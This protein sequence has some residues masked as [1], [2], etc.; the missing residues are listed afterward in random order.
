VVTDFDM[1]VTDGLELARILLGNAPDLPL[2]MVTGLER[3]ITLEGVPNIKK[4][5]LK[6][7]NGQELS[8]AI[9][10]VLG[11]KAAADSKETA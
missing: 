8:E 9:M 10:E 2:I 1:P 5:V 7:Y 6:P 4:T 11:Q 3:A